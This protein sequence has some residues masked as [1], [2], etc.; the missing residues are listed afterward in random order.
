VTRAGT[1]VLVLAALV[2]AGCGGT[3]R[4][5][6]P[7]PMSHRAFVRAAN[8]ACR[9]ESRND[10]RLKK[11]TD[12]AMGLRNFRKEIAFNEAVIVAFRNLTPPKAD[13]VAF[14]RLLR[15]LDKFDFTAHRFVNVAVAL[16]KKRVKAL[17]KRIRR[18]VKQLNA[19]ARAL[20]LRV[21]AE[22]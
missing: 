16:D 2:L 6:K 11:P 1:L 7:K 3:A 14:S 9:L 13:A 18:E 22:S 19:R 5:H 4:A 20:D 12:L 17:L 8:H 21:C 10:H 15:S